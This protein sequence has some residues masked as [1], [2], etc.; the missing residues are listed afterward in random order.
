MKK[1]MINIRTAAVALVTLLTIGFTQSSYAAAPVIPSELKFVGQ[2]NS[3]PV[4]QLELNNTDNAEYV[5]TVRDSEKKL[6]FS[7]KVSGEKISRKY[8]LQSEDLAEVAGTTFEVTNKKT[9]ETTVY[10]I[11]S[12]SSFVQ[13]VTIAKL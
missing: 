2:F 7:E 4:F 9:K 3:H 6:L 5:V 10:E 11:N 1:T 12:S 13:D 8:K